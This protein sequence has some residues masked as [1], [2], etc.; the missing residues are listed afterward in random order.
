MKSAWDVQHELHVSGDLLVAAQ[1]RA[2]GGAD[3]GGKNT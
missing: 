1:S 2:V 3:P